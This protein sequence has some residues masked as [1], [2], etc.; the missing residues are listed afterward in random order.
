[1]R[2]GLPAAGAGANLAQ[3]RA[4]AYADTAAGRVGLVAATAF[5]RPWNRASDQRPDAKDRPGINPLRFAPEYPVDEQAFAALRRISD[6][7]GLTQEL[8]RKRAQFYSAKEAPAQQADRLSLLGASFRRGK[9]F[10]VTTRVGRDDAEAN[11]RWIREARR[12]ADW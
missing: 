1:R 9:G 6:E 7:L 4:P 10:E 3:A 12:Q 11:L 5:L 2:A 8:E